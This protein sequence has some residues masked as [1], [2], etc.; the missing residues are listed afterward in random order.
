MAGS[1][2]RAGWGVRQVN[3]QPLFRKYVAVLA[4]LVSGALV[5]SGL[6]QLY[7][8]FQENQTAQLTI[9]RE[10]A[11]GASTRIAQF[12]QEIERQI[13]GAVGNGPPGTRTSNDQRRTDY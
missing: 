8:S 12:L 3:R 10:K 4:V 1:T 13:G 9:Q 7:F 6:L 2:R 5:A 11:R